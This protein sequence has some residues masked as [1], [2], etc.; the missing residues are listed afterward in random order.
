[1]DDLKIRR[2]PG[3]PLGTPLTPSIHINAVLNEDIKWNENDDEMLN[4]NTKFS[5]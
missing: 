2:D 5:K 4:P 3:A 1:M